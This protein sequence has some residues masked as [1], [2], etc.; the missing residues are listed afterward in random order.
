MVCVS[1]DQYTAYTDACNRETESLNS[2]PGAMP[3]YSQIRVQLHGCL[4]L[5]RE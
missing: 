1:R 4:D 3:R 2:G 5:L